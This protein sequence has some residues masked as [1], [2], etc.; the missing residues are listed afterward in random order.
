[1]D[2][3]TMAHVGLLCV[4]LF[5]IFLEG[6]HID[7]GAFLPQR[8]PDINTKHDVSV[9]FQPPSQISHAAR[10]ER[11]AVILLGVAVDRRIPWELY[12]E[13]FETF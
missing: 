5:I 11:T 10:K 7:R 13:S 2:Y 4:V 12:Y 9:N 3:V 1:M 6:N 8:R